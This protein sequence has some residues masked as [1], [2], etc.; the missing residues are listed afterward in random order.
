M[1]R[2]SR[3]KGTYSRSCAPCAGVLS[4]GCMYFRAPL[5]RTTNVGSTEAH[6]QGCVAGRSQ[7]GEFRGDKEEAFWDADIDG[8]SR[9]LPIGLTQV[10]LAV[11]LA[12]GV[13]HCRVV[14]VSSS[15]APSRA[16]S[17]DLENNLRENQR[18]GNAPRAEIQDCVHAM[19]SGNASS[20]ILQKIF[21]ISAPR[22]GACRMR[23][24]S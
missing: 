23:G 2:G 17:T 5:A 3:G 21:P 4:S 12:H 10:P 13:H 18:G 8:L 14:A 24:A 1:F 22:S 9:P 15:D 19:R 20:R 7:T 11:V 16:G 6:S